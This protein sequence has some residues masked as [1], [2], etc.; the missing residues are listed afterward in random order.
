MAGETEKG[1]GND[2]VKLA[3]T[4]QKWQGNSVS[5][6]MLTTIFHL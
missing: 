4:A 5:R 6:I 1:R 2:Y 3:F